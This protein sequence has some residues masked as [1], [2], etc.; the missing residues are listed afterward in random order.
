VTLPG[1]L[2]EL[3][4]IGQ[5]V[6]DMSTAPPRLMQELVLAFQGQGRRLRADAPVARTR[7]AAV[8]GTLR[9]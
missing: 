1:D 5:T 2:L 7:R 4:W 3:V 8:D 9:S 6:V